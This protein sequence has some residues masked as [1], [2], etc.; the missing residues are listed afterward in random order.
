MCPVYVRTLGG[1]EHFEAR[2][3]SLNHEMTPMQ[4]DTYTVRKAVA[5]E[6]QSA[7]AADRRWVNDP[8]TIS[9]N[10]AFRDHQQ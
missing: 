5:V 4:K 2:A 9:I 7:S 8:D 1:L 10:D 3:Y 6:H